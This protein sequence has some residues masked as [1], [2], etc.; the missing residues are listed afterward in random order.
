MR[1]VAGVALERPVAKS[2]LAAAASKQRYADS[3]ARQ[4]VLIH[5]SCSA[6]LAACVVSSRRNF[7]SEH[8]PETHLP[9]TW[10]VNQTI[11]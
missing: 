2:P 1:F 3:F 8:Y 6:F 7:P 4:T 5:N 11:M 10:G 9:I